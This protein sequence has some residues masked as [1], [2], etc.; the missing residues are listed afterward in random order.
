MEL[1]EYVDSIQTRFIHLINKLRDFGKTF[2]NK[3]CTNKILR[4]MCREWKP[5]V[6]ARKEENDLSTLD[7]TKFFGKLSEHENELK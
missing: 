7:I 2:S 3:D 6:I 1:E 4:S 5:K